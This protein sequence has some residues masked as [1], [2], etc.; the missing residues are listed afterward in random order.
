MLFV[1]CYDIADDRRRRKMDKVLRGYGRRVQESVFEADLDEKRYIEM[2]E[3]VQRRVEATEDSVRFYRQCERCRGSV[4][5]VG[6][7]TFPNDGPRLLIV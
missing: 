1:I 3:K 6:L 5:V 7:G 4:E 2:R